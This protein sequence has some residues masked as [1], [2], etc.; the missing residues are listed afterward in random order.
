[1]T[2]EDG[3]GLS[4]SN[5]YVAQ[6]TADT[7]HLAR[8]NTAWASATSDQKNAAIV[9]ASQAIDGMYGKAWP[10]ARL[11]LT[12]AMDWPRTGAYDL[13]GYALTLVPQGVADAACEGALLELTAGTLSASIDSSVEEVQVGPIKKRTRTGGGSPKTYPTVARA[14]RRIIRRT[15]ANVAL[16]RA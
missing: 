8:G 5:A 9:R 7:Y 3:T 15:G 16:S 13:D 4:S 2:V 1:M 6:T 10:G 12:Q 14:L 11:T